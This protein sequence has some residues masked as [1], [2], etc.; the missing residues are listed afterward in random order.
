MVSSAQK[1]VEVLLEAG[2]DHAFCLPGGPVRPLLDVLYDYKDQFRVILCRDEQTASCMAESYGQMTGKP[3]VF[4][5][6][7]GFAVSTGLFGVL[8]AYLASS[9]MLVLTGFTDYGTFGQHAPFQCGNG[10]YGSFDARGIFQATTKFTTVATTPLEAVQGVQLAI[11]HALSG[12]PGPAAVLWNSAA[13]G[14]VNTQTYPRLYPTHGYLEVAKPAAPSEVV[15]RVA[16]MLLDAKRPVLIAGNG[17][18]AARAHAELRK[19]AEALG[20]PVVTSALGKGVLRESHPL[21]AGPMG[22]TGTTLANAAVGEADL[23]L[24][25]G[26]RLKPQDTCFENP[27]LIDP[28]RQSLIQVDIDPRNAGWQFPVK[29][30]ISADARIFLTQLLEQLGELAPENLEGLATQRTKVF[31]DR[32]R[33]EELFER[34]DLTADSFP[35]PSARVVRVLREVLEPSAIVTTDGGNN[36]HWMLHLYETMEE[37]TCFGN[38]GLGGMSYSVPTAMT[39]KLLHPERQCVAVCGDG[40]FMMQIHALSTALQNGINFVSVV[41][42]DSALGMVK[43]AQGKRPFVSEFLDTDFAAI[44]R[45]FG[46]FGVRVQTSEDLYAG[47]R[48]ALAAQRPAVVD[49]AICKDE[50]TQAILG[51]PLRGEALKVV[52]QRGLI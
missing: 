14:D 5:A 25:V 33:Q 26:C 45:S 24:I 32:R 12:R 42:N 22:G 16:E 37:E 34:T 10:N 48:E 41:L 6:Q 7:E 9:P 3:G 1:I 20:M 47:L 35:L 4:M 30:G 8:Q 11:K 17:A 2:I 13:M 36:R 38:A 49:V 23:L 50:K 51:S 27:K 43:E 46:C 44:A 28:T 18:R 19:L 29:V 52:R 40:G 31:Q 39:A 21:A 15:H